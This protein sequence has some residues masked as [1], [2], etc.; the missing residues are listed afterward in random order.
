MVITDRDVT[1]VA[2]TDGE[3]LIFDVS[4]DALERAVGVVRRSHNVGIFHRRLG[5]LRVP[6]R[7]Q[8]GS[9]IEFRVTRTR[10]DARAIAQ[11][12]RVGL[13][14]PLHVNQGRCSSA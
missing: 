10:N 11:V 5:Q 8:I 2:E 4:D 1:H 13:Y 14:R 9:W 12:M 7:Q 3:F 6:L